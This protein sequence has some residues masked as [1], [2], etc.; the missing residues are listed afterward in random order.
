MRRQQ[1]R[2]RR[3]QQLSFYVPLPRPDSGHRLGTDSEVGRASGVPAVGVC[4]LCSGCS[5]VYFYRRV[6]CAPS[7]FLRGQRQTCRLKDFV[8]IPRNQA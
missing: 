7:H 4:D 2:D 8:L 5:D 1:A 3:P 6:H